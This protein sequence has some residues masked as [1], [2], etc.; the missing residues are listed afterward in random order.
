MNELMAKVLDGL[1]QD[2]KQDESNLN[3]AENTVKDL[4]NK[5]RERAHG[6]EVLEKA[7]GK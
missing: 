1:K 3:R 6:I 5:M 2:Q 7:L 4:G